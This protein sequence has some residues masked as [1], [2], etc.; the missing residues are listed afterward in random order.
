MGTDR[1]P[2]LGTQTISRQYQRDIRE[3]TNKIKPC[4]SA[5]VWVKMSSEGRT[6]DALN[7]LGS[8]TVSPRKHRKRKSTTKCGPSP[9][10][11]LGPSNSH[12]SLPGWEYEVQLLLLPVCWE[13]W[14]GNFKQGL[15]GF[16]PDFCNPD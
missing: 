2:W 7:R 9:K 5:V 11:E 3:Q 4:L 10:D 15:L 1:K 6:K 8:S 14:S 12:A 16:G 13:S